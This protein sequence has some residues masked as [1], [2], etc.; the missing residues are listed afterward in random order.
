MRTYCTSRVD[1]CALRSSGRLGIRGHCNEVV[2]MDVDMWD[3]D[4]KYCANFDPPHPP[5]SPTSPRNPRNWQRVGP[6]I[7]AMTSA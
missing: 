5:A 6:R 4:P 7:C 3:Y 1:V 2:R